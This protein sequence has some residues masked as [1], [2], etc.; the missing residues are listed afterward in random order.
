MRRS[1]DAGA[2]W[3]PGE[4]IAD[5]E[6][7]NTAAFSTARDTMVGF[8]NYT[9]RR[10][11]WSWDRG[12]QWNFFHGNTAYYD[13]FVILSNGVH[14]V[15]ELNGASPS[16]EVGYQ[17]SSDFGQ[18]WSPH[19]FLSSADSINSDEPD[20]S[21]D[22]DGNLYSVW[23]DGKY[24]SIGGYG[25]SIILRRSTNFGQTW[26]SE[27]L[28]TTRPVGLHPRVS[29]ERSYVGVVWND[30]ETGKVA[31]RFSVD[32]G[33]TFA[34][35][36][37]L[38]HGGAVAISIASS[39]IHVAWWSYPAG[40]DEIFYRQGRIVT[41]GATEEPHQPKAFWLGQNF[42]NPFNSETVLRFE[43]PERSAVKLIVYDLL[44]RE[45]QTLLDETREAE[46]H[47][48]RFDAKLLS[49]GIYFY[50][51]QTSRFFAVKKMSIDEI[52][53]ISLMFHN[54]YKEAV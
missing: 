13:R 25:A 21:G 49:S 8:I 23:R 20:V 34:A 38:A 14:L 5:D 47:Q 17:Y 43:L 31:F 24:G 46:R 3:L 33:T 40:N 15:R 52:N 11:G 1:T 32:H 50:K 9:P 6:P 18:T 19:I 45:V 54:K 2:T 26:L 4:T 53:L 16:V 22:D 27:Q 48:V 51:L 39:R 44:G 12:L 29:T 10:F 28:L 35:I 36:E 41:T 37:S 7:S 30:D 42:P